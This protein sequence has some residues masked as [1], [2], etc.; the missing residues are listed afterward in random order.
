MAMRRSARCMPSK[1]DVPRCIALPIT[2]ENR[3]SLRC[4]YEARNSDE[5]PVLVRW[6]EAR[7]A[8]GEL[9]DRDLYSREQLQK[10]GTPISA[11]GCR[12]LPVHR[13]GRGNPDGSDHDDAHALGVEQGGSVCR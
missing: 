13:R 9:S 8:T 3:H 5:L 2:E 12:R 11:I 10:E 6:F 7:V 4:A 1:L